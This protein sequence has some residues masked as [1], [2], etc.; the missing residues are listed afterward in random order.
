VAPLGQAVHE[1]GPHDATLRFETQATLHRWKPLA[2]WKRHMVPSQVA[3]ALAGGTQAVQLVGPQEAALVLEEQTAPHRWKPLLQPT[4]QLVPLQVATPLAGAGHATHELPHDVTLVFEAQAPPQRCRLCP[5]PFSAAFSSPVCDPSSE[6]N[7]HPAR[8]AAL[9]NT[10]IK[11]P[12]P[13][14]F[15]VDAP[16][17][18]T[19]AA[20][21]IPNRPRNSPGAT[22][23]GKICRAP[24]KSLTVRGPVA[25]FL[26]GW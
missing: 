21:K 12:L 1:T 13:N 4:P 14:R 7:T 22:E 18:R 2:H 6:G 25:R 20:S 19:T 15:I 17:G 26:S 10:I 24:Q 5:H 16:V 3:T 9:A 23:V 8:P 11:I